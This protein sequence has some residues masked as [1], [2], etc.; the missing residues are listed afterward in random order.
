MNLVNF[1]FNFS[2][3]EDRD[4]NHVYH[5]GEN[6]FATNA[7]IAVLFKSEKIESERSV[8]PFPEKWVKTFELLKEE[9]QFQD[10]TNHEQINFLRVPCPECEGTG[11]V[12]CSECGHSEECGTCDGFGEVDKYEPKS[13]TINGVEFQ[14]KHIFPLVSNGN[15]TKV[16][17]VN[18]SIFSV[19]ILETN[20]G[21]MKALCVR[22]HFSGDEF[23]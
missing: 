10:A 22:P 15:I 3:S 2:G 9:F 1:M 19:F 7:T 14:S 18:G 8:L 21:Q 6:Y 23:K 13:I 17:H 4:L 12:I 11:E 16:F 5:D 20:F